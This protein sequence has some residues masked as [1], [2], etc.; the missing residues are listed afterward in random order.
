[1]KKWLPT[2]IAWRTLQT[3]KARTRA[4][5]MQATTIAGGD[6]RDDGGD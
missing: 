3:T 5:M 4:M 2:T 1:M 6:G